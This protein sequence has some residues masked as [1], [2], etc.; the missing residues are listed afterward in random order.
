MLYSHLQELLETYI[1]G[2]ISDVKRALTRMSKYDLLSFVVFLGEYHGDY[3]KAVLE[4]QK[5]LLGLKKE[6]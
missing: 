3:E 2:N 5:L 4:I 1:N 6:V